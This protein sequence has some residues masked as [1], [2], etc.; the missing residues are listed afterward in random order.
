VRVDQ[1]TV[2]GRGLLGSEPIRRRLVEFGVVLQRHAEEE[3]RTLLGVLTAEQREPAG[4]LEEERR[5]NRRRRRS[6]R[7]DAL[8]GEGGGRG[9]E[10]GDTHLLHLLHRP[11]VQDDVADAVAPLAHGVDGEA[12]KLDGRPLQS[13]GHE[14]E[15]M[16]LRYFKI[17]LELSLLTDG[18]LKTYLNYYIPLIYF[19]YEVLL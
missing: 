1:L 18:F 12:L 7:R 2:A 9:A 8:I 3:R 4:L 19:Y 16:V 5:F 10:G 15:N 6:R 11:Q 14:T 13:E 17:K